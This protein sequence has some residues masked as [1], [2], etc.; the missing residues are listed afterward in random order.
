MLDLVMVAFGQ[1]PA[2]STLLLVPRGDVAHHPRVRRSNRYR[3]DVSVYSDQERQGIAVLGRGLAGRREVSVEVDPAHRGIGLGRA[4][5]AA[6]ATLVPPGEPLFA[7]VSP[8]NVA[9]VRAF[10][11]AGYRPVC[12]E[13]LFLRSR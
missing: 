4:M 9:S 8:G 12:S 3:T 2:P 10:L 1:P 13:V 11:A 7:Q 6:A 5:A